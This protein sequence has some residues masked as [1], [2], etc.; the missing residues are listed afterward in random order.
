MK[1]FHNLSIRKKLIAS[2]G[3]IALMALAV[4]IFGIIGIQMG[5]YRMQDMEQGPL[6][7]MDAVG[8]LMYATTDLQRVSTALILVSNQGGDSA[9]LFQTMDA[10]LL[11]M[12][13][14]MGT[15]YAAMSGSTEAVAIIEEIGAEIEASGPLRQQI[16]DA[17]KARN[18][19]EAYR[20]YRQGYQVAINTIQEHVVQL[21]AVVRE[22]TQDQ[23]QGALNT[24]NMVNLVMLAVT[25]LALALGTVLAVQVS[26]AI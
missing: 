13:T 15:I 16:V 10:D 22:F 7:A 21:K 12:Q 25:I 17:I 20:V 26:A 14:A 19:T 4:A 8:D 18:S 23:Y 5:A 24:N 6:T 3:L 9:E 1:F 11:M 2:H